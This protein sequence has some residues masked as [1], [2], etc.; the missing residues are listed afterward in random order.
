MTAHTGTPHSPSTWSIDPAPYSSPAVQQIL[1]E[2]R[3]SQVALYGYADDPSDTPPGEFVP[4]RGLFLLARDSAGQLRG[5]GGWHV[6]NPGT[7]EIKRM[8]V[9]P[10]ARG[11]ALG[12]QLLRLLEDD[13][14][15]Q[16]LDHMQLETGALNCAALALYEA[17]GYVPIPPYRL[18]RDPEIN[19]ALRKPL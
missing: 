4:P 5:C 14:R 1:R 15:D 2:F 10:E 8:Y 11:R 6:L 16:G 12:R 7:G 19:R 13:A 18:G 9:Q 17:H 3:A